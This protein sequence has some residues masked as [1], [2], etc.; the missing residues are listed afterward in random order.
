M[1]LQRLLRPKSIAVFG[2]A[3][4]RNVIEQCQRAGFS[5]DIWPV[6]PHRETICGLRCYRSVQDLPQAPDASFVGV[7]RHASVSVIAELAK[8]GAGGAVCF[9]SGFAEASAE[10]AQAA[11]LQQDLLSA[12]ADMPILGPNCYGFINYL[13][14]ALL[15][16]DQHGG[17]RCESGV[18]IITQSS[19][20]LLNLTMQKRA[21]PLAYALTAGNQAQHGLASMASALLDDPRVTAIGLHIEGFGDLEALRSLSQKARDKGVPLLALKMGRSEQAR[22]AMVSH[23]NSLAGSDAGADALLARMGITRLYSVSS[24]VESLKLL[25]FIG[26]LAGNSIS[27]LSCSG[28]EAGLMADTAEGMNLRYLA[29][30]DQRQR[31]LRQALGPLVA[32]ANPLDYHTYIWGDLEAMT[33][34]YHAMLKEG[35]DLNMLVLDFPREDRCDLSAWE[36]AVQAFADAARLTGKAAAIV[37]SLPENLPEGVAAALIEKGITPLLCIDDALRAAEAAA[38]CGHYLRRDALDPPFLPHNNKAV[39][40]TLDEARAKSAMEAKGLKIPR[41]Q[42]CLTPEQVSLAAEKL[43]YPL[44]LKGMGLAHKSEMGAVH[45]DIRDAAS[46]RRAAESLQSDVTGFLLEQQIDSVVAELLVGV[47]HD[48]AHGFV[49]TLA[50]GG[51]QT[52]LLQDSCSVLLPA[53]AE[54]IDKALNGLRM[55]PLL[56]GFRGAPCADRSALIAAI[57]AI[58][59]Y[60]VEHRETLAEIEVNPLLCLAEGAVAVDALIRH[61]GGVSH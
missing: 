60:V 7:N 59:S 55:A 1:N 45:L 23:T 27:S 61:H 9:A 5:G 57:Q 52:E 38:Q 32:L 40:T 19:N 44:V 49:L 41:S 15:W 18:A 42:T 51:V 31:D 12:A 24:F 48:P 3:W 47:V 39:L 46:A 35:A 34:T 30:D 2:G 16:P 53:S 26:P 28:G 36:P 11:Q 37:S 4:A 43:G 50:A 21:L 13:D 25:H 22:A 10:D 20:I 29:L 6:H 54:D 8:R 14:G 58:I 56:N 17:N 33:A